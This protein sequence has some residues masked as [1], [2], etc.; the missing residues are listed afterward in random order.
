MTTD[1]AYSA[2]T[3]GRRDL[4]LLLI[5]VAVVMASLVIVGSDSLLPAW[6]AVVLGIVEGVTEYLPIS[7]T[8]HLVITGRLLDVGDGTDRTAL[9]TYLI[10]IQIGAIAAVL[11]IYHRR[12]TQLSRGATGRDSDGRRM[13]IALVIAFTPAALVGVALGDAV[14]DHL[15]QP[16]PIVAAWLIG[17][18]ALLIWEPHTTST[19][20]LEQITRRQALIIGAAQAI[21]L[22]PGTSRSLITLVAALVAGLSIAAAVEFSFLLG[23]ATLTAATAW[24]LARHGEELLDTY[25]WAT[26]LLGALVAFVA[27]TVSVRWMTAYLRQHSLRIFGWYRITIAALATALILTGTI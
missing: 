3:N 17:G 8:G 21:A 19:T 10:A 12:V 18:V 9:D 26:P 5:I 24:D 15:F 6:K 25:G 7:S 20:R 27:A 13:L 23:L 4:R 16:W 11:S 2:T 22:W 14:K 1:N